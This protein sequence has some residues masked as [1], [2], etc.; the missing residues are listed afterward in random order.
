MADNMATLQRKNSA[1]EQ[2]GNAMLDV[3]V[4]LL[5]DGFASTAIG[6]LEIFYAA[7]ALWPELKGEAPDHR[8]SV[9]TVTID[10]GT[11]KSPYGLMLGPQRAIHEVV[12]TDIIIVPS[13][14]L[15]F[16]AKLIENSSLLP[17]LQHHHGRGA[18][19]AGICMGAAYLAEAGLLDGR[20]A[21]T[22]WALADTFAARYPNV[23]WRPDM[24]VTE[25]SRLLCSGGVYAANDVSLYMVEKLCGHEV[26]MQTAKSL[27]LD[28]PRLN[29]SGYALLPLSPPHDDRPI[30]EAETYVLAHHRDDIG[31]DTLA[32]KV[33]MSPRNFLRRFKAA[34]GRMPGAY[35]QAVRIDAAK[36]LLE[37]ERISVKE[38]A[39]SVGYED[40]SFFRSLFKRM[41]GMTPA[42]YRSRFGARGARPN[43]N[44]TRL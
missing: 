40:I 22:H 31:V 17:W 26:A 18:H 44:A 43:E 11:V 6:P 33:G 12:R 32:A 39:T 1:L 41:T 23:R 16:E 10:G 4:V 3:T 29:Q 8:F 37:R 27:L 38:I 20:E 19:I 36:A 34:T 13:S 25:D 21:T 9:G 15:E 24:L 30:R 42:D 28:M 5:G 7:G 2:A 14:G 35:L